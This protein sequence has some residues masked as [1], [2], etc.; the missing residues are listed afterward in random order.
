M[1]RPPDPEMRRA[2][3]PGGPVAQEDR[4]NAV[5]SNRAAAELQAPQL[6]NRCAVAY[7]IACSLAPLIWGLAR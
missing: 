4:F 3:P 6:R 2:A 1:S 7:R 5:E